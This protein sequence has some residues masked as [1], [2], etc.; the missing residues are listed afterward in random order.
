MIRLPV[1]V[2]AVV[3]DCEVQRPARTIRVGGMNRR[4]LALAAILALLVPFRALAEKIPLAEISAYLN[5]IRTVEAEFTQINDDGTISTGRLFIRRPGRIRFEYDPPDESLVL[6]WQGQV[7][8]FDAK[9]NSAPEK[10]PL[11]KTPLKLILAKKV[12]LGRERMVV[13]H[14]SDG[15]TTTV[16]AQDP[17]HPEY[18]SLEL[19]FTGDPVELRQWVVNDASGQRTTVVLGRMTLGKAFGPDLFNIDLEQE[20][21]GF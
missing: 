11:V 2:R 6:A 7:A 18:G 10:F 16:V 13:G 15:K 4:I 21:R 8:I 19:V 12:D 17:E 14:I 5:G 9:S 3:S 1:P 20:A